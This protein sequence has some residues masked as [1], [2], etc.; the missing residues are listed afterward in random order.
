MQASKL[1]IKEHVY[2]VFGKVKQS[3]TKKHLMKKN[4]LGFLYFAMS[5][6]VK[7][8]TLSEK[9]TVYISHHRHAQYIPAIFRT[10]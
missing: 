2:F 8:L 4:L 7:Y 9:V 3:K 6:Q 5:F 1:S 10:I